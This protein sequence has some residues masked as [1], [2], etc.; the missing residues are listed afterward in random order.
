[1]IN[2]A[3]IRKNAIFADSKKK[4]KKQILPMKK[5]HLFL[6]LSVL[7]GF[8]ASCT[9]DVEL[10][11]D[12]KDIPV[13]Y[14]LLDATQDT[15]FI[16]IN[17][18]FSGSND[19]MINANDIALI[20]DSCNY[21]GKLDA[22]IIEYKNVYGNEFAPT[23]RVIVLDTTTVH[24][25]QEGIFYSPDQK[26]YFTTEA[27]NVNTNSAKY[28]YRL[29]VIKEKDTI[30]SETGI[31][32]GE[33][34]EIFN[35][36]LSFKSKPSEGT[37]KIRFKLADNATFYEMKMVFKYRESLQGGP[38]VEKQVHHSFGVRSVDELLIENNISY[39]IYADNL[40]FTL[41][42]DAI[43]G[44]TMNVVRHFDDHPIELYLAAGGDELYNYIQIN[45][46]SGGF[47]QTIPDYTNI[48]GG[49][50]VFSSRINLIKEVGISASTQTD[51]YG[52]P[53]GFREE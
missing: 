44:D 37:G 23:G 41:L 48:N 46:N 43:G 51:L 15:N 52:K 20:D 47:S 24:N 7:L 21:P 16:R 25:K 14:G 32:G 49:Y 22:R 36:Q 29:E 6:S 38:E 45:T 11:A 39:F 17:R 27:F 2:A 50:G 4:N 8:F 53:W 31:V 9:T 18:A 30:S 10:Y 13:I 35:S 28:K 12:Y 26:V 33:G 40:L 5:T 1:M 3:A 34:F 42:T 19:N